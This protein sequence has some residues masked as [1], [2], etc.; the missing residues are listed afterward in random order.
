MPRRKT[1]RRTFWRFPFFGAPL[2]SLLLILSIARLPAADWEMTGESDA[3]EIGEHMRYVRKAVR[4][5]GDYS[6]FA[7]RELYLVYFDSR[8]VHLRIIDQGDGEEPAHPG[9]A[10][11]MQAN[12]CVVGCNGGF[13]HPDFAPAGLMIV[14]R[15][16]RINHF[17]KAKLLSGVLLQDSQ[18]TMRLLRASEFPRYDQPGVSALIQSGPFLVDQGKAVSSLS[19]GQSRRRTFMASD[20]G[21]HWIMGATSSLSLAELGELLA[22]PD[23]VTE[24]HLLRALNLDGGTSTGLYFD[25]GA[26]RND[27]LISPVKRVRNFIGLKP[28]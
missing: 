24:F 7:S 21:H 2:A 13:F 10:E 12:F 5:T 17:Q 1:H 18:G 3:F 14:D 22:D 15:G 20:G 16:Q 11:A 26:G 8:D 23:I 4:K 27:F 19:T 6:F 28:R 25:R 9:L